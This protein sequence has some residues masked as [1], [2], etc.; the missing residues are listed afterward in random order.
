M[1]YNLPVKNGVAAMKNAGLSHCGSPLF[2]NF[3][4]F[5]A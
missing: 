5:S 4:R 3:S 1:C 2:F